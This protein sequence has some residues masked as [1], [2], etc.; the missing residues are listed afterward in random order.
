MSV[1]R[2]GGPSR[3]ET[4]RLRTA[5]ADVRA[6]RAAVSRDTARLDTAW[7]TLDELQVQRNRLV[8]SRYRD[9]LSRLALLRASLV[10]GLME[11]LRRIKPSRN[12]EPVPLISKLGI[13]GGGGMD[14]FDN[15]F[16]FLD[17]AEQF[18]L[19]RKAAAQ[20]RAER[21]ARRPRPGQFEA[22]EPLL[23]PA[24]WCDN[25]LFLA[26]YPAGWLET[27]STEQPIEGSPPVLVLR[28]EQVTGV[29]DHGVSRG[30]IRCF[31]SMSATEEEFLDS[32]YDLP[33]A[34][35]RALR[36]TVVDPIRLLSVDGAYCY[37]F[38]LQGTLQLRPFH[39]IPS[40][41]T[42]VFLLHASQVFMMQL[43][44]DP[45]YHDGYR[46]AVSTVLGTLRWKSP[47]SPA[48]TSE[49]LSRQAAP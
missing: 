23:P 9:R 47:S 8:R 30:V 32:A 28:R 10:G 45:H 35:T 24:H 19:R 4:S 6:L 41:I 37:T 13:V 18:L 3:D 26:G 15:Y 14:Q 25:D 17:V 31:W 36:A 27:T 42:E 29:P 11:F 21:I 39:T 2:G 20:S 43:A 33:E 38:Q 7:E 16:R 5:E 34:R 49:G 40:S 12:L 44:S 1:E 22:V 46:Q 48:A